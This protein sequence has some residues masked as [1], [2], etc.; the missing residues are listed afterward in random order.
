LDGAAA[1]RVQRPPHCRP[2][3]VE[4][5]RLNH[6]LPSR[7]VASSCE[8]AS[9][10]TRRAACCRRRVVAACAS[11]LAQPLA[12]L[13]VLGALEPRGLL[14]QP[15]AQRVAPAPSSPRCMA[16]TGPAPAE[17][18]GGRAF[19]LTRAGLSHLPAGGLGAGPAA[20]GGGGGQGR[21]AAHRSTARSAVSP[22]EL[23]AS[24]VSCA[25]TADGSRPPPETRLP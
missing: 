3:K 16:A 8:V 7:P 5:Q 14:E 17:V 6:N 13:L 24:A 18:N 21:C 2:I 11:H 22:D 1:Q 9:R 25:A 20:R 10:P 23:I 15:L 19:P 4:G 12:P